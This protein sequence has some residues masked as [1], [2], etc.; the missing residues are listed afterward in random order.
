MGGGEELQSLCAVDLLEGKASRD[1]EYGMILIVIADGGKRQPPAIAVFLDQRIANRVKLAVI[2]VDFI[3]GFQEGKASR[4]E[5]YCMISSPHHHF[6]AM[7]GW[8]HVKQE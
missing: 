3:R 4:D 5:E 7:A 1:K 2:L 6:L 8:L